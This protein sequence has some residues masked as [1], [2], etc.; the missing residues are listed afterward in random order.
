MFA[1]ADYF[2]YLCT[3]NN[4]NNNIKMDDYPAD[5]YDL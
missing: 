5:N 4:Q 3:R 2:S 1:S